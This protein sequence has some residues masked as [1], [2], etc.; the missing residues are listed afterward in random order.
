M[1]C[2][3]AAAS[4][5]QRTGLFKGLPT[6]SDFEQR[7]KNLANTKEVGDAFEIL[8]EGYLHTQHTMQVKNVWLV[9]QVPL[10]IRKQLNLPSDSKGIDGI[11]ETRTGSLVPY[12]VKYRTDTAVLPY[13]EVSSFLGITERSCKDRVLFTNARELSKDIANRDGLRN[14]RATQFHALTRED[15]AAIEA[16][17]DEKPVKHERRTP[18]LYQQEAI[19]QITEALKTQPR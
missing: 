6:F 10:R 9:G 18:R 14:V 4:D 8:V 17:L 7:L 19:K 16:W 2:T 5:F 15:F 13:A 3:H 11:F 1:S 12:Q